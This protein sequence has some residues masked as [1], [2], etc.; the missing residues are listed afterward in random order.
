MVAVLRCAVFW[1]VATTLPA[2]LMAQ[3]WDSSGD[4][5][6]KYALSWILMLFFSCC[7]SAAGGSHERQ[8]PH[9]WHEFSFLLVLGR[10]LPCHFTSENLFLWKVAG[11]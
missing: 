2:A 10:L 5:I 4:R 6:G 1:A 11:Q 7:V 3:D 8:R 9:F